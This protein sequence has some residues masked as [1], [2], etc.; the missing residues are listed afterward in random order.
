M[1]SPKACPCN[2]DKQYQACCQLLHTKVNKASS[3]EQL[4]RSRYS[5]Y[6][7]AEIDYIIETLLPA[8]RSTAMRQELI[9]YTKQI[10]FVKLDIVDAPVVNPDKPTQGVVEFKAW[11]QDTDKQYYCQHERSRFQLIDGNW[12]YQDGD[13]YGYDTPIKLERNQPCICGSGK[14]Y[15]KCCGK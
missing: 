11:Y 15:K 5:A 7:T 13:V 4:M 2:P 3:P 1:S 14:K 6:A 12:Y 10:K 9:E 8:K